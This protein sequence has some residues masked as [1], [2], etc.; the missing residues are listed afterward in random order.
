MAVSSR[1]AVFLDRDGTIIRDVGYL[2]RT[3]QIEILPG[4]ADAI[5]LL[6]VHGWPVVVVTN[7]SG[8][9]RGFITE[10]ALGKIHDELCA[11][12]ARN[13]AYVSAIYFCP[14]HPTEGAGL[15]HVVCECRKPKP[16][17]VRQASRDLG[18]DP[19]TSYVVGDKDG[20][21]ELA[22]RVGATGVLI[23]VQRH[24][25]ESFTMARV[26]G[27]ANL[28]EAAEWIMADSMKHRP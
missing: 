25:N 13:G 6:G 10:T 18:L 5:R 26:Y 19:T 4:A 28:W 20:D 23:G 8:V 22:Q 27:A 14:H 2:C 24:I 15:Y 3:D 1:G 17:M 9:A 7:Q 12:L 21:M 11:R 16:G